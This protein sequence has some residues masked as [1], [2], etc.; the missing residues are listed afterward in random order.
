MINWW[1]PTA[2]LKIKMT[3]LEA[4]YRLTS[5]TVFAL[6]SLP[7]KF[8]KLR[9]WCITHETLHKLLVIC[10]EVSGTNSKTGTNFIY[11]H[12]FKF[13]NKLSKL[14]EIII[15]DRYYCCCWNQSNTDELSAQITAFR[16][17]FL[18]E[19]AL[20]ST[21]LKKLIRFDSC[22]NRL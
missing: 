18:S 15:T 19:A 22:N 16:I 10:K 3:R 13:C 21:R 6:E 17:M 11:D 14:Q 4:H 9:Y 5:M 2:L 20:A 12:I 8:S 7:I 1:I